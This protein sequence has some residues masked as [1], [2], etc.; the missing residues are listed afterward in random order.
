MLTSFNYH[1]WKEYM[2]GLLHTKKLFRLTEEI[3]VE[4]ILNND[5]GKQRDESPVKKEK[6]SHSLANRSS[7]LIAYQTR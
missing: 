6:S 4:P 3:E 2:E 7:F 1:Q 5:K